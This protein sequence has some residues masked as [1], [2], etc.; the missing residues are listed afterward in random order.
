MKIIV[1]ID[2]PELAPAIDF[3]SA[4]LELGLSRIIDDDV[5]ELKGASS[6]IYLLANAT[7]SAATGSTTETRRYSRHWT[8]VHIDYVVDD[9]VKATDRALT[10]GAIQESECVNWRGSKCIT[11]SD[12]FGHGFCLIEFAGET[13]R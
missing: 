8:P 12:P 7:G 2:V 11:F 6:V 10:A 9:L 4:A 5:A 3:Y 1:N 13:Y